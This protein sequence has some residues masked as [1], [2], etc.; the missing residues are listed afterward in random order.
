MEGKKLQVSLQGWELKMLFP[1]ILFIFGLYRLGARG[2]V[3]G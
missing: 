3:V 2:S 1:S